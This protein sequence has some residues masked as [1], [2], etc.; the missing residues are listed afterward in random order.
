MTKTILNKKRI[1]KNLIL[2]IFFSIF[3]LILLLFVSYKYV[4][5]IVESFSKNYNYLFN[6]VEVEGLKNLTSSEIEKYFIE[7][8]D[9]SIFLIPLKNISYEIK[10]NK[11][12]KSVSLKSNFKNKIAVTIEE[13]K[14]IGIYF[15]GTNYLLIDEFGEV[16][17]FVDVKNTF[18][19]I[20]FFGENAKANVV[21]FIMNIPFSL[22][23][24]IKEAEYIN[25][26]RWDI[27]LKNN[28]RIKL[29]EIEMREALL[30]FVEIYDSISV[31]DKSI[32]NS[33]D[34]RLPK[35]AIIKF[36]DE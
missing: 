32:I 21:N 9:K 34:L 35:K 31:Q 22:N 13:A 12:I 8:Y 4:H 24:L 7:H 27:I 20:K 25:K 6:T 15:N 11:W 33:F 30:Q 17:D 5:D 1:K 19:Y 10:T 18:Q 29:P 23:P 26:R 2:K 36:N 3:I 16:I 14:P 28:I